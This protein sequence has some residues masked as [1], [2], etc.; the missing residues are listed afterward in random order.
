MV[1]TEFLSAVAAGDTHRVREILRADSIAA[2]ART[3]KGASALQWAVYN[4]HPE[5]VELLLEAG[6]Q[7]DFHSAC[8]IGKIDA[9]AADVDVDQLSGDGFRP[10]ALAAAFGHNDV[11]ALLLQRGADP[12]LTSPALG[13]VPPLQAAVFGRNLGAIKL[14]VE[15]GAKVDGT[16]QGGFTALMGA[17]Q[18]GDVETVRYLL[19]Q[20]ADRSLLDKDGKSAAD[21]ASTDA[22]RAAISE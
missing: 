10:L 4:R 3:D 2:D 17:A 13:D 6:A 21:W 20:G 12:N 9:I 8:T 14:L 16:Q 15:G 7:V 18:N 19:D 11:V 22:A 5:V 1:E